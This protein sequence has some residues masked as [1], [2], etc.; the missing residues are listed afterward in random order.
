MKLAPRSVWAVWERLY[1][2]TDTNLKRQVAIKVLPASVAAD[3][4]RLA[5]FQREGEVLASLNHPNIAAIYGLEDADGSKALVMELVDGRPLKGPM[6]REDALRLAAQIADALA[7]AHRKGITHR[8][9]KPA[10]ILV[11]KA[12]VKLLDF[13]LAKVQQA[14]TASDQTVT[15]ALTG[16]G[17]ILGTLQY[18][19]PEQLQGKEADARSDIFSF[20]LVLYE[21]VTGRRAFEGS[22][23]ASVIAA[24]LERPAPI[25]EPQGLDRVVRTCLAKDP[26]ERFQSARDLKRAIEWSDTARMVEPAPQSRTRWAVWTAAAVFTLLAVV[27]WLRPSSE[28]P[29]LTD[30]VLTIVP[31]AASGIASTSTAFSGVRISPDGSA[32]IY[33]DQSGRYH[34]RRLDSMS[35]DTLRTPIPTTGGFWA[36]D[37]QSF[38]FDGGGALW[39]MRLPDGVPARITGVQGPVQGGT[40]NDDGVLLFAAITTIND[41]F[42][43]P[44]TGG[45]AQRITLPGLPDGSYFRPEFLP[46]TNDFLVVFEPQGTD[47]PE[48]YLATFREGEPS[49]PVLLMGNRTA[50]RYTPA[51]GGKLLFVRDDVLYAQTLDPS[52]RSLQGDP[53]VV[54]RNVASAPGFR[55]G[56]F[57]V[58]HAGVLAWRPGSEGQ[59]QLTTFDRTGN[60]IG[61]SGPP[62]Q[63]LSVKLAPDERRLLVADNTAQWLAEPDRPGQLIVSRQR[64]SLTMLWSADSRRF[65][66]PESG[67]LLERQVSGGAGR[68]IAKVPDLS[69]L[70]DVSPDGSV[71]LFTGGALATSMFAA[72]LDGA[73]DPQPVL[74]TGEQV[75]NTRFAPDGRW[76]VFEAYSD[77][78]TSGGGIYVQPFPGPGLRRQISSSGGFPVWRRD[79][80]EIV[81]LNEDQLWSVR[82]EPRGGDLGFS[83]PE[84]LFPVQQPGGVIDVT[85]LAITRNGARIYMP[86][87]IETIDSDVIH[88]RTG[89]ATQ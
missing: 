73:G 58:S 36:P 57:S 42:M 55:V 56:A 26:D 85:P 43:V 18:M 71:V 83:E 17:T 70:E 38:V 65:L 20:G 48:I 7:A 31:P 80:A 81:F 40:Q 23:P 32:V 27:G 12:G 77:D 50:P 14:V 49:D 53:E 61:M 46:G 25:L 21:M 66:I 9:L 84:P 69:R 75:F 68:E 41:L 51:G 13:G 79:G 89:W 67:R 45:E 1:R 3:A 47:D 63:I 44:A 10:N 5:R 28:G 8:D 64:G 6:P 74:Q 76:I 29:A 24:I 19:S 16:T 22:S 34:L 60:Q 37:S 4:E 39:R 54:E 82:V 59:V 35:A 72:R 2:A 88:I 30:L 52:A 33:Q 86:Q 15:R 78:V 87:P 62:S 11:T